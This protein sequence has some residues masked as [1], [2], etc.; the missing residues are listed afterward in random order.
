MLGVFIGIATIVS[1]IAISQGVKNAIVAQFDALGKDKMIIIPGSELISSIVSK[2]YF[3]EDELNLIKRTS[4]VKMA[5]GI[6]YATTAVKHSGET[7]YTLVNGVPADSQES[8][9]FFKNMQN[10]EISSGRYVNVG[11]RGKAICGSMFGNPDDLFHKPVKV[12][13][14]LIIGGKRFEVVGIAEPVGN[15]SDD[16]SVAI[17]LEDAAEIFNRKGQYD[18]IIAEAVSDSEVNNTAEEIKKNIRKS[19][20]LKDGKEDFSVQTPQQILEGFNS[21]L[22]AVQIVVL[23]I[24]AI[25]IIVGGIGIMNTMYTSVLERTRDI[26]IMKAVGAKNSDILA[27]FLIEAGMLGLI[28]GILGIG[29]GFLISKAVEQVATIALKT[30][31][32]KPQFTISLIIG[33]IVFSIAV[34]V[35][36]G[37]LPARHAAKMKVVESIRYRL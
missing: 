4:G 19:R 9:N 14:S 2:A 17:P 16:S 31:L 21:I 37:L 18:M 5:A 29:F 10:I 26:G 27:I 1:L 33:S 23:G 3:T 25:S 28:G 34:G 6:I 24:A 35:I 20:H 12:G 8:L 36:S 15:P 30:D 22:S 11:E 32:L 13:D 7:K